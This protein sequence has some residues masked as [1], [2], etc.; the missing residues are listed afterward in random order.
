MNGSEH[1]P[2]QTAVAL[3]KDVTMGLP[4]LIESNRGVPCF[5]KCPKN[6]GEAQLLAALQLSCALRNDPLRLDVDEEGNLS[7]MP[8]ES[9]A[10]ADGDRLVIIDHQRWLDDGATQRFSD[11]VD[12]LIE[13]DFRVI[14]CLGAHYDRYEDL[15]SDRLLITGRMLFD[16]GWL[17]PPDYPRCL[18]SFFEDYLP[19]EIRLCA[20]LVTLMKRATLAELA[21]L[22]YDF[23]GD[24]PELLADLNPLYHYDTS[25]GE[26]HCVDVPLQDLKETF[27]KLMHE[28]L[29]TSPVDNPLTES[30]QRLTMVSMRLLSRGD[31]MRS[32]Q[33]LSMIE[34][35]LAAT[36]VD[37]PSS[38]G[39]FFQTQEEKKTAEISC[40]PQIAD[41]ASM[42][43][44]A[45][46][47][48]LSTAPRLC[49]V[50]PLYIKLFGQMELFIGNSLLGNSFLRRRMVARML[51]YIVFN[52]RRGV[53]R[54]SLVEY[55]WP[56]LDC[57]HGLKNLYTTWSF[58]G[59]GL[60]FSSIKFCP[61]IIR[62][63][64]LYRLNLELVTCDIY[65]FEHLARRALFGNL[66]LPQLLQVVVEMETIYA[67][68]IVTNVATDSFLATR[69][70][71]LK[72]IMVDALI[73]ASQLLK[74]NGNITKAVYYARTA[75]E[76]DDSREDVYRVLMGVQFGVGQRTAAMQTYF[77]CKQYLSEEL[78]ILPSKSTT[79]LYQELLLADV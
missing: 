12:R 25:T 21:E 68:G 10:E 14:V 3:P 69:Q 50:K 57:D 4:H 15:Q 79:D 41:R 20:A 54:Q 75:Y 5:I 36:T 47:V 24:L 28:Y 16:A 37:G 62:E 8:T 56:H 64:H 27:L 32:H 7:A 42:Q 33:I 18:T 40:P 71:H 1:D 26:I 30:L 34:E 9:N 74:E 65:H 17:S 70:E 55:L 44:A 49:D 19:L 51:S 2:I 52:Q 77:T 38:T 61:Y 11:A 63:G 29:S 43:I 46:S 39:L 45:Y 76:I 22:G 78:G 23:K 72:T 66:T 13:R 58:L 60:G 53:S 59:R 48:D 35:Y 31:L 6:G 67:S 73:Q